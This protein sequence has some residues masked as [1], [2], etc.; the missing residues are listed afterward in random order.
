MWESQQT[1]SDSYG[2][3]E[4]EAACCIL[5]LSILLTFD[6]TAMIKLRAISRTRPTARRRMMRRIITKKN[7]KKRKK[8]EKKKKE[9]KK[10]AKAKAKKK[11]KT[12]DK[13]KKHN[14]T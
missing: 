11:K 8:K 14:K 5:R 12:K 2:L 3:A 4:S 7:K 6:P 13:K 9:K 1:N 10:K